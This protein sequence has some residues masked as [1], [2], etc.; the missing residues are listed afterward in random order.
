M[1]IKRKND[2]EEGEEEIIENNL[3]SSFHEKQ[4]LQNS[5]QKKN[6]TKT[7]M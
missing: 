4:T 7:K 2:E 6:Q 1:P 5:K 3:D